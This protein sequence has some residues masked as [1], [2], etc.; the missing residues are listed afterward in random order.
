MAYVLQVVMADT[1]SLKN[2]ALVFSFANTPYIVT[3]FVGPRAAQSFLGPSK[4]GYPWAY[5][6][7]AIITPVIAMPISV[8][9]WWNT[10]K[11]KKEDLLITEK[12]GRSFGESISH[13]FW[14]F[15][16]NFHLYPHAK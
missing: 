16:S 7:F 4:N 6:T 3:T 11:A 2:R 1:S 5:G 13:Y 14:E 8:V 9:L 12:S 10:R 15:D